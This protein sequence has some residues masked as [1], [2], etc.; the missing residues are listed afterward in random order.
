MILEKRRPEIKTGNIDVGCLA[1][2]GQFRVIQRR[3]D[4]DS[5]VLRTAAGCWSDSVPF[6]AFPGSTVLVERVVGA[7]GVE[8]YVAKK[9]PVSILLVPYSIKRVGLLIAALA[10]FLTAAFDFNDACS[11]G[12]PNL[13]DRRRG[14]GEFLRRFSGCNALRASSTGPVFDV[15][16]T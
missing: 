5:V 10:R 1:L 3:S 4:N 2:D 12:W 11:V 7:N 13:V 8:A 14:S 6:F 16:I 15:A 9:Y